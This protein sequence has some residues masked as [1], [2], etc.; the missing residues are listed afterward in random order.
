ML[1][2]LG[3]LLIG[4]SVI[5]EILATHGRGEYLHLENEFVKIKFPRNWFA[6]S[7]DNKN[8]TGEVYSV[9]LAPPKLMALII[10]RIYDKNATQNFME[11][12]D[13]PDALSIV[14]F[15]TERM[16]NWVCSKNENAS[17][18]VRETGEVV[19][20]GNQANYSKVII[21]DG[22]K[23]NGAFHNLSFLMISYIEDQKLIEIAFWGAKEDVEKTSDVF[24]AILNS[25]EIKV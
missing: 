25:T 19:V 2:V 16:Y 12:H 1:M 18:I 21:K 23:S 5:Y 20:L 9:Y 24:K 13:L 3:S 7:W 8:S 6:Y 15:E 14:T 11:K 17:L 4:F 10:F 22:I